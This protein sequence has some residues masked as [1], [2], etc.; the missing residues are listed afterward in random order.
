MTENDS[1]I[2]ILMILHENPKISDDQTFGQHFVRKYNRP[3]DLKSPENWPKLFFDNFSSLKY[4][5]HEGDTPFPFI[6]RRKPLECI[7]IQ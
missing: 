7:K 1:L 6:T 3:N 5:N 4:F 2:S